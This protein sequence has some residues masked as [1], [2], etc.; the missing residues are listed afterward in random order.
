M[1]S[2]IDAGLA[3]LSDDAPTA[4]TP[5]SAAGKSGVAAL[6]FPD[7]ATTTTPFAIA[8]ATAASSAV[9]GPLAPKLKLMTRAPCATASLIAMPTSAPLAVH[10]PVPHGGS[11]KTLRISSGAAYATPAKPKPL[12]LVAAAIPATLVPCP[13]LSCMLEMPTVLT[14]LITLSAKTARPARSRCVKS[15]PV[16]I[17][18]S[19]TL[20][21]SAPVN[22]APVVLAFPYPHALA[23]QVTCISHSPGLA[24][25]S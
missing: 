6:S 8:C 4:I 7:A 23:A 11:G 17:I 13:S 15:A 25:D 18:A 9:S 22:V 16:S 24:A 5:G 12:L 2:T 20:P 14:P 19:F 1:D 10:P 3:S 21:P